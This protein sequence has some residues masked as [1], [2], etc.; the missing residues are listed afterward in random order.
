MLLLE[1]R[2]VEE[3]RYLNQSLRLKVIRK[4]NYTKKKTPSL[5]SYPRVIAEK[6]GEVQMYLK[7][8][9]AK[10]QFGQRE[11]NR[12]ECSQIIVTIIVSF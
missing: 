10:N 7:D 4:T 5:N 8:I 1:S 12:Q 6:M 2:L 3:L 11:E 9:R